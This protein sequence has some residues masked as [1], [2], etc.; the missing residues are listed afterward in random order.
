MESAS[1]L[2]VKTQRGKSSLLNALIGEERAIVSDEAGTTRD[3][4]EESLYI[5]EHQVSI[6]DTAGL[7]DGLSDIENQGIERT[8]KQAEDS[9]IILLVVDQSQEKNLFDER[10]RKLL[11]SKPVILIENKEDLQ[12]T[13]AG[14]LSIENNTHLQ[15][16]LRL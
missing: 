9:D 8:K 14:Y 5:G 1:V 10:I 16:K 6:A 4:I 2:L 7:R 12:R 3:Y 13:Q 15:L 11:I